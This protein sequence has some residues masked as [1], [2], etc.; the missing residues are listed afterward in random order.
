ML[1][2]AVLIPMTSD[3]SCPKLVPDILDFTLDH[4]HND[5]KTLKRCALVSKSFLPTSQRHLFSKYRL[6]NSNIGKLEELFKPSTDD[7][8]DDVESS[9]P[10]TDAHDD[11]SALL[12][13]R[14]AYLLNNYTTELTLTIEKP[15]YTFENAQVPELKNDRLPGFENVQKIVF[16]GE[17]LTS[18]MQIPEFLRQRWTSPTSKILSVGFDVRFLSGRAIVESLY[19][20]PAAVKNISF[21]IKDSD[22]FQLSS[23]PF[24]ED[25]NRWLQPVNR[26]PRQINGTLKLFLARDRSHEVLLSAIITHENLFEFNLQRLAYQ[27]TA[28]RDLNHL[29]LLVDKCKNTLQH[30]D[31]FYSSL[32][33]WTDVVASTFKSNNTLCPP[34][35]WGG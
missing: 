9:D 33:A 2:I 11:K 15:R 35:P 8:D 30:L 4:L 1:N 13:A 24:C 6:S 18:K 5:I 10:P 17:G 27:L 20:L 19:T 16:K 22:Y 34:R 14:V 31:I 29:A 28:S 32:C 12:R 23:T 7:S 3:D 21:A 25:V 26:G